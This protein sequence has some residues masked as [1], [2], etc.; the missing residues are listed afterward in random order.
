MRPNCLIVLWRVLRLPRCHHGTVLPK[1]RGLSLVHPHNHLS[2]LTTSL[3]LDSQVD[4]PLSMIYTLPN[5]AWTQIIMAD[6]TVSADISLPFDLDL[7]PSQV[8]LRLSSECRD[9][10]VPIVVCS[11][12]SSAA[13]SSGQQRLRHCRKL[14]QESQGL[15]SMFQN[16]PFTCTCAIFV[17]PLRSSSPLDIWWVILRHPTTDTILSV[18]V[19]ASSSFI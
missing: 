14:K 5:S 11:T 13:C 3:E 4:E 10:A 9:S 6:A 17:L 1:R 19:F 15:E 18:P 12:F 16:P 2:I 7:H 8:V